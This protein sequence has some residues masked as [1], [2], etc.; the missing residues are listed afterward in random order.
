M[1]LYINIDCGTA[2]VGVRVGYG[3]RWLVGWYVC[4]SLGTGCIA[5]LGNA[6]LFREQDRLEGSV[7]VSLILKEKVI[8]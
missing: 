4:K 2:V 3:C 7:R 1:F 8:N 6:K 5:M